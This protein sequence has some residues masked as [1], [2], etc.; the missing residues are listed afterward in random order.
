ML[1]YRDATRDVDSVS[2]LDDTLRSAVEEVASRHGL[3]PKWLND[4]AAGFLP[5]TFDERRCTVLIEHSRLLVLGAPLDQIFVM[6]L[7]AYRAVDIADLRSIWP[8]CGFESPEAAADLYH[9]AYPHLS[10]DTYLAD[11]IR[12]IVVSDS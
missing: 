4:A 9:R 5:Q 3:A 10:F 2:S 6:K 7:F 8:D 1:G 12:R 11:E